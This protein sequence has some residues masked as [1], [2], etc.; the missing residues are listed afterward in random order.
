MRRL[1]KLLYNLREVPAAF[2]YAHRAIQ[3]DPMREESHRML[4][5]LYAGTGQTAEAVR[6]YGEMEKRLYAE[7]GTGPTAKTREFLAQ[8]DPESAGA[9]QSLTNGGISANAGGFPSAPLP[10]RQSPAYRA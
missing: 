10:A 3:V 4:L 5:Q 9:S 6:H 8:L 7:L 2:E 1:V